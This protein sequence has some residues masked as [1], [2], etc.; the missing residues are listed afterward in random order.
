MSLYKFEPEDVLF[1][2]IE[3]HPRV[4]FVLHTG[5][6]IYNDIVDA[7]SMIVH[8]DYDYKDGSKICKQLKKVY[9]IKDA[10]LLHSIRSK[11]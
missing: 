9:I 6:V 2:R 8:K 10:Y 1:N 3:S 5:S 7:L 4:K 11:N